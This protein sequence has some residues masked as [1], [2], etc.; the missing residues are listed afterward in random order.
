MQ[1]C[2]FECVCTILRIILYGAFVTDDVCVC[3]C[4]CV[5]VRVCVRACVRVCLRMRLQTASCHTVSF[6]VGCVIYRDIQLRKQL[7]KTQCDTKLQTASRSYELRHTS[8]AVHE[9]LRDTLC[10]VWLF[11][12]IVQSSVF[13]CIYELLLYHHTSH[14]VHEPICH[15]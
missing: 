12:Y 10:L 7:Y 5:C 1:V 13:E 14:A 6:I 3:V 9:L 4:V 11:V 8:R 2:V 15:K